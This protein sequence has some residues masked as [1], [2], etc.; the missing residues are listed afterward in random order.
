M[1][2]PKKAPIRKPSSP[3]GTR[4]VDLLPVKVRPGESEVRITI[5][6]PAGNVFN[7]SVPFELHAKAFGEA[8]DLDPSSLHLVSPEPAFPY[9]IP[10]RFRP[11]AGRVDLDVVAYYCDDEE[12][13]I[14]CYQ[15]VRLRLA[16]HVDEGAEEARAVVS[17]R[18]AHPEVATA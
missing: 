10:A 5:T 3:R 6:P 14:C 17:Y 8:V 12:S 11:G 4:S 7:P 13:R 15:H 1:P 9:G 2:Q 16:I 18:L